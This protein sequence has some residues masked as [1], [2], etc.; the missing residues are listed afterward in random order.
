MSTSGPS[1]YTAAVNAA[2][3]SKMNGTSNNTSN[4]SYTSKVTY[5]ANGGK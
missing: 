1:S 3:Q 2:N 5:A 4:W